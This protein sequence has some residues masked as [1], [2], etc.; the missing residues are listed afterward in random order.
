MQKNCKSVI[1]DDGIV[2]NT[3]STT[4]YFMSILA[5]QFAEKE[6]HHKRINNIPASH[7]M[8]VKFV[9]LVLALI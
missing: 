3:V 9:T 8:I 4:A 1:S 2:F 6:C 7:Q 5:K